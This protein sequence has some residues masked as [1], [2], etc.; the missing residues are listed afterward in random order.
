MN[1]KEKIQ[2]LI[3]DAEEYLDKNYTSDNSEFKAW[4]AD[5]IRTIERIYGKDSTDAKRFKERRYF[6]NLVH[7]GT[8]LQDCVRVFEKDLKTSIVELKRILNDVEYIQPIYEENKL[9]NDSI[10]SELNVT[11]NNYNTNSNTLN[12]DITFETLINSIQND[13]YIDNEDKKEIVEELNKIKEIQESNKTKKQKWS[14]IKSILIFLLD[15]GADFVIT[16]LPEILIMIKKGGLH[17]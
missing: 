8:T 12:V 5:L 11:L 1:N 16:Y 10:K 3:I 4:N 13:S 9:S 2:S 15:K 14:L 17:G 6:P 7:G